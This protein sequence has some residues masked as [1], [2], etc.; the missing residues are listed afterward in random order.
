MDR[1][2]VVDLADL[3]ENEA[4]IIAADLD[5]KIKETKARIASLEG[6]SRIAAGVA[7]ISSLVSGKKP[8]ESPAPQLTRDD[9]DPK[10]AADLDEKRKL[11]AQLRAESSRLT[12]LSR[13]LG[14]FQEKSALALAAPNGPGWIAPNF[15][16]GLERALALLRARDFGAATARVGNLE[17]QKVP[18][19]ASLQRWKMEAEKEIRQAYAHHWGFAATGA[20]LER[21]S[22]SISLAERAL[23]TTMVDPLKVLRHP[24]DR[25]H[26]FAWLAAEP[27]TFRLDVSWAIYWAIFKATQKITEETREAKALEDNFSGRAIGHLRTALSDWIRPRM[28]GF[29]YP[30]RTAYMGDFEL[31]G[32]KTE[33]EYGGDFAI[34]I[35][36]DMGPLVCRKVVLFQAKKAL[37]GKADLYSRSGQLNKL[38]AR[39][40][41]GY[42][43]FW[44][45]T[46]WPAPTPTPSVFEAHE[47]LAEVTLA[48]GRLASHDVK[49]GGWD[50]AVFLA[51]ALCD[52]D[53]PHGAGFD[54]I[55]DAMNILGE[56]IPDGLPERLFLIAIDGEEKVEQLRTDLA[57][58]RYQ[59]AT[60]HARVRDRPALQPQA[61]SSGKRRAMMGSSVSEGD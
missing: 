22:R 40:G 43:V 7:Y 27:H 42:Y 11:V 34:L 20:H 30:I 47:L 5:L 19:P 51:F 13:K 14:V 60:S 2:E 46:T 45:Q 16:E 56:G 52:P 35:H 24:A 44:N 18:N 39:P 12:L 6:P 58:R 25:W 32:G 48:D 33:K 49:D 61:T 37:D 55:D 23:D 10:V 28:R 1:I 3:I 53:G 57:R 15:G 36:I 31:A 59:P 4:S 54:S 41:I 21:A 8:P 38:A 29:G 26:A 50:F 9:E 17:W